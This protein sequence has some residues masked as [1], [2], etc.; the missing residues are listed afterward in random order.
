MQIYAQKFLFIAYLS[1]WSSRCLHKQVSTIRLAPS[2]SLSLFLSLWCTLVPFSVTIILGSSLSW[3][4]VVC[5]QI[6]SEGCA[7]EALSMG[8]WCPRLPVPLGSRNIPQ[9]AHLCAALRERKW[10]QSRTCALCYTRL[11][12]P[13]G[14]CLSRHVTAW[15][16]PL[17]AGSYPCEA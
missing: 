8:P 17:R 4:S 16:P 14:W 12:C 11:Q 6:A 15:T 9:L 10:K 3:G 7:R 1:F 2:L 5:C 13:K